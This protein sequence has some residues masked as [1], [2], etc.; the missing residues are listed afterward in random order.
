MG[1]LQVHEKVGVTNVSTSKSW[2]QGY[3]DD[4]IGNM[5]LWVFFL[6]KQEWVVTI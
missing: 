3:L 4:F 2:N 1:C 6:K 5:S